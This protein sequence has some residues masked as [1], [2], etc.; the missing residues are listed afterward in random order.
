MKSLEQSTKR[1]C[2]HDKA[3]KL[4]E[5]ELHKKNSCMNIDTK[6]KNLIIIL[7][8][9]KREFKQLMEQVFE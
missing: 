8:R 6:K 5:E 1:L 2:M 3:A 9:F 7:K 4:D